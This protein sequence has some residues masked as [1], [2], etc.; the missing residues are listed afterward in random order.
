LIKT[1]GY[2]QAR[3]GPCA[4]SVCEILECLFDGRP[5]ATNTSSSTVGNSRGPGPHSYSAGDATGGSEE[6]R[7]FSR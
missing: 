7:K 2:A 4:A 5:I 1:V 6:A 3:L